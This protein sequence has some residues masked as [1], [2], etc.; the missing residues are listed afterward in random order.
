MIILSYIT[1]S[2]PTTSEYKWNTSSRVVWGTGKAWRIVQEPRG[3]C[4]GLRIAEHT[5]KETHGECMEH[6]GRYAKGYKMDVPGDIPEEHIGKE[7]HEECMGT[8]GWIYEVS[9]KDSRAKR[10]SHGKPKVTNSSS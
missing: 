3:E 1:L 5:E 7:T 4:R 6:T 8:K 10:P 2:Y 9:L